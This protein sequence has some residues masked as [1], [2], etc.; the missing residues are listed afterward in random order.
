MKKYNVK[1]LSFILMLLLVAHFIMP[2]TVFAEAPEDYVP[3]ENTVDG[4]IPAGVKEP[5]DP[6]ELQKELDDMTYEITSLRNENTKHFHLSDGT[7]QAV[8]YGEPVHRLNDD[9]EWEEIDNA[10]ASVNGAIATKDS[11][12]KFAKKITGNE[13]LYTL[14]NGHYKVTVGL[15]GAEKKVEGIVTSNS[16]SEEGMTK[17][18]RLTNIENISSSIVYTD[19]LDG[20]DL[21]YVL[22]SNSIKENIIV[23]EPSEAYRY[24]FT[25]QLNGLIAELEG[26]AVVLLDSDTEETIYRIPAPFMYD[27]SGAESYAAYYTLTSTGNGKYEFTLTADAEWINSAERS[28]PVV[29]DPMLVDIGQTDDTYVSSVNKTTGYGAVQNLYVSS[30]EE[31]YY[32]FA[33]PNLPEGTAVTSANVK[34]P[35]YFDSTDESYA[36]VNLYEVTSYWLEDQITWNTKPSTSA[37]SIDYAILYADGASA[38]NPYYALFD[39]TDSVS[40]WCEGLSNDGFALKYGGGT[41]S[42]VNFV[43]KEKMQKFAQLTINYSGTH[44]GEGV[45]AIKRSDASY[46]VKSYIPTNLAWVLQD[47]SHTSPPLTTSDLEN[48]FKLSYRPTYN[49]YVIRSMLDSSLILYPSVYNNA[50]VAGRRSESDSQIS[51]AYTWKIEYTGGYYY[52]TYT[53]NGTKYYVRSE[54]TENGHKLVLTTSSSDTGTK[55]GFHQYTGNVYEDIE[56]EDFYGSIYV[57]DSLTY[58]AYMRS[59]RIGH[60]G[61]VSYSLRSEDSSKATINS[62][63]GL[64]QAKTPGGIYLRATYPGAPWIWSWQITI[65]VLPL[66]GSEIT[67]APSLW[68]D[69]LYSALCNN[70]YNYALN[71]RAT[72]FSDEYC[73][74]QPGVTIGQKEYELISQGTYEGAPY[75]YRQLK[76]G[77][78][79][80]SYA[81]QDANNFGITF[82]PIGK[83]EVCP[84]GTYKI[85]LVVD[86]TDDPNEENDDFPETIDGISSWVEY[87]DMDYHWYRQNPDGTWSHKRGQSAV[88]DYDATGNTIYDPQV[89]DRNYGGLNYSVFVGYFAVS[90]LG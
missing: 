7:Y 72:A 68:N 71:Y 14:H 35:Y 56:M 39:V 36:T 18:E 74:M 33:T 5:K 85:A 59:T 61:P 20:V 4:S 53:E 86:L 87:P 52:I 41:A 78:Q 26:G 34:F 46:Y 29:I 49:D 30:T 31:A 17:L 63:T 24:T 47:T 58:S 25:L 40:S 12:V 15:L 50:P 32:K 6:A 38:G 73:F 65:S 48:L 28:F 67:Y 66:S 60:N 42:S 62:S 76:N 54:S 81:T 84:A 3:S 27:A 1:V 23:K 16:A 79:L 45:Y 90:P 69:D 83:N 64:L 10:L 2:T 89:C 19:I 88:I 8:V 22:V 70:C 21:E 11:R 77:S 13:S 57:G 80:Q 82:I 75:Y 44:L 37:I 55:W 43:A 51:T 9:G